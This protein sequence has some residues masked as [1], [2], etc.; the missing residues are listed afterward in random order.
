MTK[1]LEYVSEKIDMMNNKD[2]RAKVQRLGR[3]PHQAY[4]GRILH[5]LRTKM[6]ASPPRSSLL[7]RYKVA[8]GISREGSEI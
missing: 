5:P 2:L 4:R 6:S 1:N 7:L 8:V 3:G